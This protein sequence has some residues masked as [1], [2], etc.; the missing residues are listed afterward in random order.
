MVNTSKEIII[1]ETDEFRNI[2]RTEIDRA[3]V[4]L[5]ESRA[6][7]QSKIYLSRKDTAKKIGVSLPTLWALDKKG[8]L[9]AHRVGKKVLYELSQVEAFVEG[10]NQ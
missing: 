6:K 1:L 5:E 3:I 2:V 9:P 7:Q 10:S 4:Q 8:K